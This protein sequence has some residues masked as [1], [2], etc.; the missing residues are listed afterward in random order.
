MSIRDKRWPS[1]FS[2][3]D[4][5][6]DLHKIDL[7]RVV[8]FSSNSTNNFAATTYPLPHISHEHDAR[9]CVFIIWENLCPLASSSAWNV[10]AIRDK[11]LR[12][13]S[14]TQATK[15][16]SLCWYCFTA[17]AVLLLL[18]VETGSVRRALLPKSNL[19]NMATAS[20]DFRDH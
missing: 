14:G 3:L 7:T 20:V 2:C 13:Q 6:H 16:N 8:T 10:A 15:D 11:R 17:I 1:V 18:H 4:M 19:C 9:K 12:V 5:C